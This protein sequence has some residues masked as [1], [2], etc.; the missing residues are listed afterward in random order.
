[1]RADREL[2][3]PH[4][5][6]TFTKEEACW[7]VC[8]TCGVVSEPGDPPRRE[9]HPECYWDPDAPEDSEHRRRHNSSLRVYTKKDALEKQV[10]VRE[11]YDGNVDLTDDVYDGP[12]AEALR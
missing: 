9:M 1:M 4:C 12:V 5:E 3:C 10:E 6:E 2:T 8:L 7:S 11:D